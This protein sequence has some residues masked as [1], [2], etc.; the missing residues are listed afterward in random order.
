MSHDIVRLDAEACPEFH[1]GV[2]HSEN[3]RLGELGFIDL[4]LITVLVKE[5]GEKRYCKHGVH[6]GRHLVELLFK[7]LVSLIQLLAHA[8]VLGTLSREEHGH[9]GLA[10]SR[11]GA[12]FDAFVVLLVGRSQQ[13]F[14][15]GFVIRSHDR[16]T[17][18]EMV[19]TD[20]GSISDVT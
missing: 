1:Q 3:T 14:R 11:D 18:V 8:E 4:F 7:E 17:C 6:D 12:L 16:Q 15:R 5:E 9:F 13:C 2:L 19:T 10:R 20:S